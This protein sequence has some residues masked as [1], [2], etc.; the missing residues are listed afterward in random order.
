V[1]LDFQINESRK[2]RGIY[3]IQP[4]T[5]SDIRGNIWT[6]YLAEIVSPLIPNGVEFHHDKFSSS[7][8]D[9]LRGIHGDSKSWKLVTCVFG[10]IQQVVIDLR[11][12]S[13]T[14]EEWEEFFISSKEPKSILIPPYFGNAYLV[15]S[16]QAVYHYKL[17]Y[18]GK[19]FD[20]ADQFTRPWNDKKINIHWKT[21]RPIL[22]DRD[23]K[24]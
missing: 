9:V 6:S 23:K 18:K 13:S 2:I 24:Q 16:H 17:A 21:T 15:E 4:N 10:E 7:N 3:V 19:Y 14:Y 11:K 8:K 22:S 1:G 20:A 12:E 5:S